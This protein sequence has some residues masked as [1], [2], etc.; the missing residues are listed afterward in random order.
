MVFNAEHYTVEQ[1]Q[2][3]ICIIVLYKAAPL[4]NETAQH[5]NKLTYLGHG[6]AS[7]HL[8]PSGGHVDIRLS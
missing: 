4:C 1:L 7:G 3:H 6:L 2:K 8:S 5:Q